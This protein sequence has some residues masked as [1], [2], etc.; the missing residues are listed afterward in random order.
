M[1]IKNIYTLFKNN[2]SRV[3]L[4]LSLISTF[5]LFVINYDF[6]LN[7][8]KDILLLNNYILFIVILFLL[9]LGALFLTTYLTPKKKFNSKDVLN[10]FLKDYLLDLNLINF[11]FIYI[12][13]IKL[14]IFNIEVLK[15]I[16]NNPMYLYLA[17]FVSIILMLFKFIKQFIQ[18]DNLNTT[19][20][21]NYLIFSI[22]VLLAFYTVF[23]GNIYTF[24]ILIFS[25]ILSLVYIYLSKLN[26]N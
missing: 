15:D 2:Y 6:S 18:L 7:I 20:T 9:N 16:N 24:L 26:E 14:N 23:F 4:V 3:I 19:N 22:L 17:I 11:T 21:F 12:S 10:S 25:G 13:L 5:L 8:F 1:K